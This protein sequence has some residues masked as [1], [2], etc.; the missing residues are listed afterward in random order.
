MRLINVGTRD[1]KIRLL[2]GG[3]LLSLVF[4]GPRTA[5]GWLGLLPLVTGLVRVCPLYALFRA[6]TLERPSAAPGDRP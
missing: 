2:L 1:Q 5:W 3:L 4:W 6:S